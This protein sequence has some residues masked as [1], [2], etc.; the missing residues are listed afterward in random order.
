MR[1]RRGEAYK[2]WLSSSLEISYGLSLT[3]FWSLSLLSQHGGLLCPGHLWP[4]REHRDVWAHEELPRASKALFLMA[5]TR[6]QAFC[7]HFCPQDSAI[8][9]WGWEPGRLDV[10]VL[11]HRRYNALAWPS[12]VFPGKSFNPGSLVSLIR[13][14]YLSLLWKDVMIKWPLLCC[15][16]A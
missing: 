7:P 2:T 9:F 1:W 16:L 4:Y 10:K 3:P 12:F 8:P 5:E 15:K 11:F 14:K 6:G 13:T